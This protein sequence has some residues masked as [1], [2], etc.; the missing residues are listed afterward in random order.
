MPQDTAGPQG[1]AN[2]LAASKKL[3]ESWKQGPMGTKSGHLGTSKP[4]YTQARTQRAAASSAPP[5]PKPAAPPKEF[6]GIRSDE[7]PELNNA[8]QERQEANRELEKQ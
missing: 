5:A 3:M 4:S 1:A 2:A 8:L 7:G 6:M